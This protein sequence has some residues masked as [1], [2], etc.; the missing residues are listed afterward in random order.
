MTSTHVRHAVT[1]SVTCFGILAG[2]QALAAPPAPLAPLWYRTTVDAGHDNVHFAIGFNRAPD[3]TTLD[4]AGRQVDSFQIWTDDNGTLPFFDAARVGWG[5]L[6]EGG[7]AVLSV[8]ALP[9][10]GELE[11]I[12]VRSSSWPGPWAA[13]GWGSVEARAGYILGADN[14]FSFDVPLGL[15]ANSGDGRFY[16]TL[17]TYDTGGTI[18]SN[19]GYSGYTYVVGAVPEPSMMALALAG[20]GLLGVAARRRR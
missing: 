3:L 10:T 6:P 13:G 15:L 12:K 16:Y 7:S 9:S 20:L 5:G 11:Y 14:V 18:S 17:E 4:A 19:N 2:N 1:L 8:A